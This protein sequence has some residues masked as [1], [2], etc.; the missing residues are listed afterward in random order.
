MDI[1][2]TARRWVATLALLLTLAPGAAY[3]A[4]EGSLKVTNETTD[5]LVVLLGGSEY[6]T[7]PANSEQLFENVPIG[8]LDIEARMGD[9]TVKS[10]GRVK[11]EGGRETPYA[12][13]VPAS[14]PAA[15]PGWFF[16]RKAI[17]PSATSRA[18]AHAA[19]SGVTRNRDHIRGSV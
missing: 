10:T 3:A 1:R 6:G 13:S 2:S 9:G 4:P 14:V 11:I 18:A 7:I 5:E 15:G 16:P 8:D 12:I 19:G 17:N